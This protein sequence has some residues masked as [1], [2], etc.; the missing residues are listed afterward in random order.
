MKIS[1]LTILA[2]FGPLIVAGV[3]APEHDNLPVAQL[4]ARFRGHKNH[5]DK[6]VGKLKGK[7]RT[8]R[9]LG[10]RDDGSDSDKR[11]TRT[12]TVGGCKLNRPSGQCF[13]DCVGSASTGCTETTGW[14]TSQGCSPR[15]GGQ[16]HNCLCSCTV[17]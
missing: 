15:P 3:A 17:P 14:L 2:T 4:P 11:A 7:G 5:Q 1:T 12:W 8:G 13:S 16:I 10:P 9:G 6:P